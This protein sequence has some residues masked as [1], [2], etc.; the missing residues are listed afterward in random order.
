MSKPEFTIT[1][2]SPRSR[3]ST[4]FRIILVIP[5]AIIAGAWGYLMNALSLVQ[6]II[7]LFTGKRNEGIWKLQN[8]YLGYAARVWSY[9]G[10]MFDKWP[11]IGP[12]PDGEPTTYSFQYDATASRLSNFFRPLWLIPAFVVAL[13]VLIGAWFALVISWFAILITGRHPDFLFGY[14]LKTHRFMV[15][16]MACL[17]HMSDAYPKFSA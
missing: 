7:I 16:L 15:H 1:N 5:H 13:F 4:L 3:I 10:L 11:A 9:Y 14:L 8:A 2:L 17:L 6:W 12:E